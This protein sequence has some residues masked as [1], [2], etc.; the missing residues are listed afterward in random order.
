MA[1]SPVPLA[2]LGP[3]EPSTP[4]RL[5]TAPELSLCTLFTLRYEAAYLMPFVAYHIAAGFDHV[6]LY[7]DD[8]TPS[9]DNALLRRL[10]GVLK[11]TPQVTVYPITEAMRENAEVDSEADPHPSN[12]QKVQLRHCSRHARRTTQ[13][14]GSWD[15]DEYPVFGAPRVPPNV[16]INSQTQPVAAPPLG[17]AREFVRAL[18]AWVH[19]VVVPRVA[20]SSHLRSGKA[21]LDRD[22]PPLPRSD[23]FEFEWLQRRIGLNRQP[24][25]LWR[26]QGGVASAL[27]VHQVLATRP[28]VI[29]LPDLTP[30]DEDGYETKT[31]GRHYKTFM[32]QDK[33]AEKG[34]GN[35]TSLPMRLHHYQL[36]SAAE[37]EWKRTCANSKD[38]DANHG[39]G[40]GAERSCPCTP[41]SMIDGTHLHCPLP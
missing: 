12:V 18:P 40:G 2:N 26:A 37:C 10:M 25:P 9:W 38:T 22:L 39:E 17:A 15:I 8:V 16:S 29:V 20:F 11:M 5:S 1:P 31:D 19:G 7:H 24:K 4:M 13:W 27:E 3:S 30:A 34:F 32:D 36:R 33:A 6:Y 21:W 35:V 14:V 41:A 23:S 28:G